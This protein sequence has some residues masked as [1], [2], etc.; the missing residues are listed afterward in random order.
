MPTVLQISIKSSVKDTKA[1]MYNPYSLEGKTILI[2]GAA[3]GIGKATSI[4]SSKM[5]AK[6]VAVD[7]N[8]EGLET[9][10]SQMEGEGHM[11]FA[12]NLCNGEFLKFLGEQVPAL[13]GVF[14]C[15]GVSDTTPVKFITEEKI[16]RV[17]DVNLT[18]PIMMLKQFLVKKKINK[19]GSLVWMSS[20]GAEK[21]EPGLGIYAASKQ[22]VNGIMRAYAR[23]LV[24]RKIRSNSIMPMMIRTELLSTL[25]NISD[26]DWEKQEAM[27]PLGFGNPL[28]VAYAAIYLFSDASRW[29]T[30]TQIKMDG[31]SN[32]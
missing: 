21:V 20:Y 32:L 11:L 9:L 6:I 26:K 18:A 13:D 17:F 4:E 16:N 25:T 1:N 14:L 15:A 23:E 24:S 5:G 31:G 8:V 28:D 30:G 2:T 27:Y 3:S 22:A 19:G 10:K 12:G 7:L 29:I